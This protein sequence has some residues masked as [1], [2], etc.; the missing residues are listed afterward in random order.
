MARAGVK[1]LVVGTA[2]NTSS[3]ATKTWPSASSGPKISVASADRFCCLKIPVAIYVTQERRQ[4]MEQ[5]SNTANEGEK[6]IV[7]TQVCESLVD[8]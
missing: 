8:V 2:I 4:M 6:V 7:L 3:T 1:Q 5:L